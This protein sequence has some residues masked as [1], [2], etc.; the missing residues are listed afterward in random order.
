M[1]CR[2]HAAPSAGGDRSARAP[3]GVIVASLAWTDASRT[4]ISS[5]AGLLTGTIT[6]D[7]DF[8]DCV[9][10]SVGSQMASEAPPEQ[11]FGRLLSSLRLK[12]GLTQEELA[13]R[14]GVSVRALSDI[15]RSRTTRP[16]RDSVERLADALRLSGPARQ[17]FLDTARGRNPDAPPP[18]HVSLAP[19]DSSLIEGWAATRGTDDIIDVIRVPKP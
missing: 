3:A 8:K 14:S 15:E 5:P 1:A 13:E 17:H 12:A 19:A 4:R 18:G 11:S 9:E 10:G 2:T 6:L 7:A 16:Y